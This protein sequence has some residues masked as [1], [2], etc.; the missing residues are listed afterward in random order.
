VSLIR[1]QGE[2]RQIAER[3]DERD[4]FGRQT[5]ARSPNCRF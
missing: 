1:Q 3:I 4:D 5:S 2:A